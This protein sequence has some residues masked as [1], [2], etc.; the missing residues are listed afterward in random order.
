VPTGEIASVADSPFDFREPRRVG[1]RIDADHPQL[2]LTQGYDHYWPLDEHA[3][4]AADLLSQQSGIRLRMHTNQRGLQFYAGNSLALATP[5]G[6]GRRTGLCLEPHGFPD[7][8]NHPSFPSILLH[9]G[10][11]YRHE[12]IYAFSSPE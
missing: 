1:D 6:F 9:P 3:S 12:T 2:Q 10:E 7:A 5:G 8:L 4:V 11:T